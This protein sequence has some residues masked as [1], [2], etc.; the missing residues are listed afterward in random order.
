MCKLNKG[1]LILLPRLATGVGVVLEVGCRSVITCASNRDILFT[2][3][4]AELISNQGMRWKGYKRLATK[5]IS[6]DAVVSNFDSWRG[7][8]VVIASSTLPI[9]ADLVW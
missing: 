7:L 9:F 2:R 1:P 8:V 5:D 4:T 6:S 3:E